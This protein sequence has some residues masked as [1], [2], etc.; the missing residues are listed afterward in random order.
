MNVTGGNAKKSTRSKVSKNTVTKEKIEKLI[1]TASVSVQKIGHKTCL[2]HVVLADGFE[3]IESA[4]C[5][6]P[7]NYD[8]NIGREICLERIKNKLWELEGYKLQG[9]LHEDSAKIA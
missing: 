5:V 4:A 8:E 1:N 2:T 6:D 7:L 3:M 9:Q